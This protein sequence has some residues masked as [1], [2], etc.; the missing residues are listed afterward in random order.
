MVITSEHTG[1]KSSNGI[2]TRALS[3]HRTG[4]SP[5]VLVVDND[6]VLEEGKLVESSSFSKEQNQEPARNVVRN[7][8]ISG[9]L[10]GMAST[11]ILYPMD[12]LRTNLQAAGM[13]AAPGNN[14]GNTG[15][16]GNVTIKG[17]RAGGPLQVLRQT[18]QSG[19]IQALYT[20]LALPLIAQAV[21]KGTVF[22]VNNILEEAILDFRNNKKDGSVLDDEN[23]TQLSVADRSF[24]GFVA[25]AINGGLF[26]TPVEYVRNQV[27]GWWML[28]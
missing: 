1:G 19:G 11:V 20:G 12:F 10:S 17:A 14:T 6:E 25:G 13:A 5:D 28:R 21:Y 4:F 26:V 24:C 22:T 3:R 23:K 9:S 7:S 18:I 16:T 8:L 27:S 15:N 2:V